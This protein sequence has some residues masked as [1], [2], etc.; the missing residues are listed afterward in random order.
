M[1][2]IIGFVDSSTNDGQGPFIS[3]NQIYCHFQPL[4]DDFEIYLN[5]TVFSTNVMN[6]YAPPGLGVF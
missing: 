5:E 3:H 1:T 6:A 2:G 4:I